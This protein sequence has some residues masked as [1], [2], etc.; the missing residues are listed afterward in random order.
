MDFNYTPEQQEFRRHLRG[1]LESTSAEVFETNGDRD[2]H[3]EGELARRR[4]QLDLARR[5]ELERL[6]PE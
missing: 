6:R 1:W 2:R 4:R 3:L 5:G